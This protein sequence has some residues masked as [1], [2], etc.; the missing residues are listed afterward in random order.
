MGN[1]TRTRRNV[2]HAVVAGGQSDRAR[3][4]KA[5]HGA[6]SVGFG[7]DAVV[8]L[9]VDALVGPLAD[10][11]PCGP[12]PRT[13]PE[14]RQL[15]H[16]AEFT[17]DYRLAPNGDEVRVVVPPA[18]AEVEA[19][20]LKLAER[21]RDLR[22]AAM[23]ARA[24]TARRGAAGLCDGLRLL[25]GLIER[26]WQA[27]HPLPAGD[28]PLPRVTALAA[29]VEARGLTYQLERMPLV[30]ARGVGEFSVRDI[31]L[32]RGEIAPEAGEEAPQAGLVQAAL[33]KD[34]D[35]SATTERLVAA[36]AEATTLVR[37]LGERLGGEA[38]DLAPLVQAI[39]RALAFVGHRAD[40]EPPTADAAPPADAPASSRAGPAGGGEI[41]DR[42]DVVAT[43]DRLLA[44]YERAEPASPVPLFLRRA[45]RLVD[46]S[47]VDV[48][49]DL[50][51]ES[52]AQIRAL[53]G[54]DG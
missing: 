45:R 43:L 16:K 52:A 29:L 30:S 44:Y 11:R 13:D 3:C 47:F 10:D 19:L 2:I 24:A 35:L 50:L 23:I 28:D 18:W 54:G 12:D 4:N 34:E 9:D 38:P 40:S 39:D 53:G 5:P 36:R 6:V 33:D 46:K 31:R 49:D 37:L 42:Q 27:V 7:R 21:T 26:H 22:L 15:F 14:F 20:A 32:A 48:I 17:T 25:K 41:R 1:F 51:P 8:T